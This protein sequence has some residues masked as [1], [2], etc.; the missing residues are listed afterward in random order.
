MLKKKIAFIG[1]GVMAEAMIAGLLRKKLAD[2]KN[3]IASGPREE[4]GTELHKK[5]GIKVSTDNAVSIHE[6][7]VVVLSV[8]PQ[9]LTEVMKGLKGIRTDALVLSII[10]GATMKKIGTGLKHKAIVRSMPNTPGQIGEGITVWT[11]S[12][13]VTAEQQEMTRAILGALGEEVFVEDESYLDMATALSGSGPAYVFLFTE[14][15]I[16]AGVHMGFPR[17]I[18]EQLVLQTV[19]G[20]ASFYQGAA[21]HP[22]TLRNQVTSPGGTSAEAL[23][24][25]EKAGFRTAIS[26]AVWAAYQRSLELGKE[27]PGHIDTDEEK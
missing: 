12:R 2:A 20:S 18:A 5:Y 19:K 4:R 13:E 22:A 7:D 15:L 11:A 17:R 23:Y 21:R 1:P 9:R 10:A 26:R 24:Y 8:K 25:L 14:A 16:D 3:I 27:K 6:A